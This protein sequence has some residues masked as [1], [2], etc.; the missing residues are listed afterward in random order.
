MSKKMYQNSNDMPLKVDEYERTIIPD[1]R[2]V[3]LNHAQ[4]HFLQILSHIKTDKALM[5]LKRLV[6]DFYAQQLQK[7]AD[8]CWEEGNISDNLLN[9][10]LRTPYK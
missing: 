4:I 8:K 9:E 3:G 10:H 1:M 2:N 7:E 5:D 6:R